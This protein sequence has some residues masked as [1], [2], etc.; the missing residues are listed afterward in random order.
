MPAKEFIATLLPQER[1]SL[2]ALLNHMAQEGRIWN[3]KQ[4]KKVRGKIF[5]F[6]KGQVR[7]FAFQVGRTWFLTNGYKKK[8]DPLDPKE[9]DRAEDI[10]EEHL[11]RQ[12]PNRG[13]R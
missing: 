12:K 2:V 6:K 10:R 5:E 13:G 8:K 9:I 4:F 3:R 11:A 7:L 1:V